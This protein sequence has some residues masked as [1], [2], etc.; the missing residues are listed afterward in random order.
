[1]GTLWS[2]QGNVSD[3]RY[4]IRGQGEPDWNTD[5]D[6]SGYDWGDIAHGFWWTNSAGEQ[7]NHATLATLTEQTGMEAHGVELDRATTLS[8]DPF[9]YADE[10]FSSDVMELVADSPAV[11]AGIAVPGLTPDFVGAAPDLGAHE[12]GSDPFVY[13][14]R[15]E[16]VDPDPDPGSPSDSGAAPDTA[17]DMPADSG[18]AGAPGAAL[19]TLFVPTDSGCRCATTGRRSGV[20]WLSLLSVVVMWRRK[21]RERVSSRHGPHN[22]RPAAG[23]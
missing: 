6:Y 13:G 2:A 9:A 16:P 20:G 23:Q 4:T 10:P 15:P 19:P 18:T 3:E 11:D 17:S 22:R 14:P 7:T 21:T 12:W 1:M 8:V 5:V